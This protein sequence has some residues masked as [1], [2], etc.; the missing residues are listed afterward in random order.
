MLDVH[1]PHAPTH[2]WR[3][4]FVHIA[5]IVIGLLIAI[6]LEQTVEYLHHRHE[7][8]LLEDNLRAEAEKRVPLIQANVKAIAARN[9]WY[10]EVLQASHAAVPVDGFVTIA[11]PP[12]SPSVNTNRPDDFAWAAAK[13]S[14]AVSVLSDEEVDVWGKVDYFSSWT[15]KDGEDLS[16]AFETLNAVSNRTGVPLNPATTIRLTT[17]DRDELMRAIALLVEKLRSFLV[18]DAAW[19][20]ASEAALHGVQTTAEM[21]PYIRRAEAAIPK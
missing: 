13:A 19:Q 16:T 10:L 1:P 15:A 20:G 18:D 4:F 14:G 9:N 7:R 17:A 5:T 11:L 3:D 21:N 2:T 8:H 6:G 12:R